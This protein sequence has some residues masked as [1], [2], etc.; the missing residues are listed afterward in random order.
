[1]SVPFALEFDPC[2]MVAVAHKAVRQ[3]KV[4]VEGVSVFALFA[5]FALVFF[6]SCACVQAPSKTLA[7]FIA[8]VLELKAGH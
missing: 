4:L 1:M 8:Q 3:S 5:L 7:L 2:P 6:C